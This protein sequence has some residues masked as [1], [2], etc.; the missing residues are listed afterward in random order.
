MDKVAGNQTH[1]QRSV[2]DQIPMERVALEASLI[3]KENQ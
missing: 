1:M 3:L 2:R